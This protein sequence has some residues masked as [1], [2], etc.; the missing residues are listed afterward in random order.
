MV[1]FDVSC[2]NNHKRSDNADRRSAGDVSVLHAA[3]VAPKTFP[4]AALSFL[5]V[6]IQRKISLLDLVHV[7]FKLRNGSHRRSRLLSSV[8]L[9]DLQP[10]RAKSACVAAPSA[11]AFSASRF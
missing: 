5:W 10:R 9:E 4:V 1:F 7:S 8:R 11:R 6:R 3:N 2:T